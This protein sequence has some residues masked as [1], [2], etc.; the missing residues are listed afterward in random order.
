[1][2]LTHPHIGRRGV[3][4]ASSAR[5][6]GAPV[7]LVAVI[8]REVVATVSVAT[9]GAGNTEEAVVVATAVSTATALIVHE[10]ATSQ[11]VA[12]VGAVLAAVKSRQ[13]AVTSLG[14]AAAASRREHEVRAY[15]LELA[16]VRCAEGLSSASAGVEAAVLHMRA[17]ATVVVAV[18]TG[19]N[20]RPALVGL[21]A[22]VSIEANARSRAE[23]VGA[24]GGL[25]RIA[26]RLTV[27]LAAALRVAAARFRPVAAS[28]AAVGRLRLHT[29]RARLRAATA[30]RRASTIARPARE[31]AVDGA[32]L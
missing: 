4:A 13:C 30:L 25:A 28:I 7:L 23:V 12:K 27:L 20:E 22:A 16:P 19:K 2:H 1:M 6:T 18:T 9:A 21:H 11:V 31:D 17:L 24:R 8:V 10:V 29:L 5:R 3:V 15:T 14:T 26:P 32:T